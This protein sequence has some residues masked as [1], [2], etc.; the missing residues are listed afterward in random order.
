MAQAPVTGQPRGHRLVAPVHGHQVDVHVDEQI[1]RGRPLVDLHV[2]AVVGQ[3]Q[4]DQVVGVLGIVLL[5]Q[6]LRCE[7]VVD[8]VTHTVTHLGFGQPTVKRQR[9]DQHDVVDP[10]LGGQIEDLLD[11]ELPGVGRAHGRKRQR[12]VV[13]GDRQLHP[14]SQQLRQGLGVAHRLQKRPADTADGI[15]ERIEGLGCVQHTAAGGQLLEPEALAVPEQGG[16]RGAVHLE[17]ESR[18]G[19]HDAGP[20]G[21]RGCISNTILV[22]PRRPAAPAWLTASSKRGRAVA[23]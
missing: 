13:E 7:G 12:H 2:L 5:Q 1:R 8:P 19:A 9:T 15:L 4:V 16:R 23:S 18:S 14:R 17:D 6:P 3:A 10:G 11:H 21:L 20:F 22:A